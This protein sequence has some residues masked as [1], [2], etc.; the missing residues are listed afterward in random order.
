MSAVLAWIEDSEYK[1]DALDEYIIGMADIDGYFEIGGEEEAAYN[2]IWHEVP[3][4]LLSLGAS[5]ADTTAFVN[6]EGKEAD[7]AAARVGKVVKETLDDLE[8]DDDE[9]IA[10]F[11]LGED[12]VFENASDHP[13]SRHM[14]LEAT[15]RKKNVVRDGKVVKINKRVSGKVRLSTA[16]KASLRK[17]RRKATPLRPDSIARSPCV[18]APGA[19]CKGSPWKASATVT[20]A[21]PSSANAG[22]RGAKPRLSASGGPTLQKN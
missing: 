10:G 6:G 20:R 8:A 17:A 11:A 5:E 22:Y 1:Y 15:Y 18:F 16:Q 12:A 7:D 9:L 13:E 14:I 21:F 19:A 3:D 2:A 4:A